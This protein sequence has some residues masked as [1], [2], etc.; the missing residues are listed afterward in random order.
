MALIWVSLLP[1]AMN[2]LYANKQ[3]KSTT[4]CQ[5]SYAYF[6][7]PKKKVDDFYLASFEYKI[8]APVKSIL[9]S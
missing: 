2:P 9:F 5:K 8:A 3:L 7:I 4:I 6:M 1:A